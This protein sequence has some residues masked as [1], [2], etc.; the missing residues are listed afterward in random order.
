MQILLAACCALDCLARGLDLLHFREVGNAL[1]R[2]EALNFGMGRRDRIDASAEAMLE[3]YAKKR[4][5]RTPWNWRSADNCN[6]LRSKKE[7]ERMIFSHGAMRKC[8][9]FCY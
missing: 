6:T 2:L 5:S 9:N 8:F 4:V 3:K 7:V 1:V